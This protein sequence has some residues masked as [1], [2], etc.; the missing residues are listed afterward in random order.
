MLPIQK[1]IEAHVKTGEQAAIRQFGIKRVTQE[2][3][4]RVLDTIAVEEPL[5][6]QVRYWFKDVPQ[7]K[8]MAVTMRTPGHDRELTAGYLLSEGIINRLGDLE[9]LRSLGSEPSNEILAELAREVDYQSWQTARAG[10][11]SSSCGV[12]G[13]QNL[14]ALKI[15]SAPQTDHDFVVDGSLISQLPALLREQQAGFSKTGGLHAAA[16]INEN[17]RLEA[18]FEDIGRHNALDKLLGSCLLADQLPLGRKILFVSS[19]SSFEL[20]QK[21]SMAGA[22]VLASVGGPSSL[23][24]ESAREQG[25]TLIGFVRDGRFNVYSSEWR[26]H[27][28]DRAGT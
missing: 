11:V 25:I 18:S 6:M 27:L 3:D 1:I 26:V 15:R 20:V 24:V 21:A 8:P 23:A 4:E 19:R 9:D 14:A 7:I 12:C 28:V 17:G 13:K 16:L 22:P 10:Y 2:K 5:A